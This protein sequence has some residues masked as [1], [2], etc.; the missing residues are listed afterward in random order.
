MSLA[1][2]GKDYY[3]QKVGEISPREDYYLR[4]GLATGHWHGSG[5]AELGLEGA[6][7]AEGLVRLFDG[8]HPGTGEQLGRKLR[9][10]GVAAWD[11]TFSADKSV[12]LLWAF[13]DAETRRHVV[14]AF[15]EA[16]AEAV[17]YME[18][19]ASS[20]RG[21][22]RTRVVDRDGEPVLGQDG[23]PRY[24]TE[25][26]P[27]RSS[28][29]VSAWFTEFTSRAD[30]PQLHTHVVVANRVKGVD[31]IWRAID[32]R[33]LYR[34]KL[35]AG[36]LHE[37]ELRSRLT[38]RLGVR[39]QPVRKGMADIEGFTREQIMAFSQRRQQIE[40]WRE[41]H[42]IADTASGNEVATLATRTPKNDHPLGT[43]MP[44]WLERATEVGL[45]PVVVSG[46]LNRSYD[47][48]DAD[49]DTLFDRLASSDGLTAGSSTFGRAEIVMATAAALPEGGKRPTV[50]ALT[51]GF[52]R[53]ADVV[54]ILPT[55]LDDMSEL[56]ID[57]SPNNIE[58]TDTTQLLGM[59]VARQALLDAGYSTSAKAGD[60][61]EFNRDRTSV[62]MGVTGT[63][64]LVI[65][66]G[67]RLGHPLWRK[68]LADAGVDRET[69]D[70]VV[71]RIAAGYVPWQENSFPGLL[72]NVAAGRIANRFDLGGTN[73]VVD[74][75]CASSLS[76]IHMATMELQ[77][78]RSDMCIAGGLDTFNS[79]FMY[80]CFSKTPALSPSGN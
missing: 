23:T 12:S 36:Y 32:G 64:E 20:T 57:L 1:K 11:L 74:A 62:I 44:E 29:Y 2:A 22:S 42:G 6:V 4:G 27:I 41:S 9:T 52:L 43:L 10:D 7:S 65:P 40:A 54:P 45:T 31:G 71:Q 56:P 35:A 17:I 15:E 75:A 13:G 68:A 67:A 39:W 80:M 53:R 5:A 34:N 50:E 16:T 61:R 79:I 66:L 19:V 8:Q 25:T 73:C 69:A 59:V 33:L 51:D 24:L 48:A 58:A 18:S 21:A 14:A 60:G 77:A 76:A 72:G 3:L 28:G 63:L 26:W 55:Q 46:V 49:P 47:I 30:D 37:A 78:G 70:D 38:E